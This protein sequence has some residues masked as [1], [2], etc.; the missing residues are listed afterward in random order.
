MKIAVIPARGG[1]KR[2]PRKNLREF[3]GIPMVVRAIMTA[4]EAGLFDHVVVSTDDA[5]IAALA[6]QAGGEVPFVRPEEL[7]NDQ[8]GTVPVIAHAIEEL[9]RFGCEAE[10]ACCIYPCTPFLRPSDLKDACRELEVTGVDFVY[11]VVE[12]PHPT[13]RAMRRTPE[14]RMQF[15]FPECE[16]M[17]TQELEKTYHDAG[18]FYW[19]KTSAWVAR[20]RMHT[21][22]IG[23]VVPAW[24]FVDIDTDDDWRRAEL[25]LPSLAGAS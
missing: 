16:M 6:K 13:F 18:Q 7:A 5:E 20:K 4:Q 2:I 19:G 9:A 11:P 3:C 14:G 22:G 17:R 24:R 25:M 1:S 12:Y 8:A 10:Y 21:A 15:V 23:M